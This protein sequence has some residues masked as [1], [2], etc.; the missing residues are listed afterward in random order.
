LVVALRAYADR[1]ELLPEELDYEL[2]E[3]LIQEVQI[4]LDR[5]EDEEAS[6]AD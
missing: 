4:E 6:P 2:L 5:L 3:E 1:L